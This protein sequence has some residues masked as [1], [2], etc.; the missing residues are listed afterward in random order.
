MSS[1]PT[2]NIENTSDRILGGAD[3]IEVDL[4]SDTVT[5]QSGV[6][7]KYGDLKLKVSICK[8]IRKNRAYLKENIITQVDQPT[9]MLK[10]ESTNGDVSLDGNQEF[11]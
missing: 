1:V 8:E 2:G 4:L 5:S 7:V 10:L 3:E 6:N 11:L 9:G